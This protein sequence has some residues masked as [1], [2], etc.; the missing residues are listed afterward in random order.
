MRL[1]HLQRKEL[2]LD[3]LDIFYLEDHEVVFYRGEVGSGEFPGPA[4][5]VIQV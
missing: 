4:Y 2:L 1:A 3:I 5:L